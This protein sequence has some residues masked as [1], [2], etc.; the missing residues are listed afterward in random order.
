M[1]GVRQAKGRERPAGFSLADLLLGLGASQEMDQAAAARNQ[2]PQL[3]LHAG[4]FQEGGPARVR[5]MLHHVRRGAG[6]PAQDDAQRHASTSAR[7][8][9][10]SGRTA[11]WPTASD[12]CRRNW[13][14]RLRRRISS[15]RR[16]LRDEIKQT[17]DQAG[18]FAAETKHE[19][20]R[21][22]QP[23]GRNAPAAKG[24]M[25]ALSCPAACGWRA[26]CAA[27]PFP[28]WAKKAGAHQDLGS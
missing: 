3:R 4:G 20:S 15:R 14:R 28:G 2:M 26:I 6:R 23:A 5:G 10:R 17:S 16:T 11:I 27:W 25:T 9:R 13:T 7:R 19:H 21:I 22:S 24:R 8:R 12:T 1:R 18:T